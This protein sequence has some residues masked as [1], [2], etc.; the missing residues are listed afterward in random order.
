MDETSL[1]PAE[2]LEALP[3]VVETPESLLA[4]I[5]APFR[6]R[7]Q[8]A[9]L[10]S[11]SR[12]ASDTFR[13]AVLGDAEPGR[14]WIFR[15]LFNKPGVFETQVRRVQDE[16]CDFTMQL[17]DMVSRGTVGNYLA[18][19]ENLSAWG[20]TTPYLTT[21]GNHDR[22]FPHGVTDARLYRSCF[23][24]T[25]YSYD[26]GGWR[27]VSLDSS[28]MR[29]TPS[30]LRWLDRVLDTPLKTAVFTHIPPAVL[31]EWTDYHGARGVGG[32][33]EGA[34]EFTDLLSRRAVRRVYMGHIHAFGVQ[35]YKGVRYVLTGG[36]G[37]PLF[38]CG[39]SDRFHHYLVV[40]AGP[41]GLRETVRC[42]DGRDLTIPQAR[43]VLSRA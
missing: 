20:V 40:T 11:S 9:R 35:D 37:S 10:E 31:R 3:A 32:F 16:A 14:F 24:S 22:R 8:L 26:R 42:A 12:T 18:F 36:G 27:F 28:A 6:T 38:P 7:R 5:S 43:V 19:F 1:A 17:G 21:I 30:Q 41:D 4:E 39:V 15:R 13:F 34:A 23:G 2:L 33:K 29:V 25:N